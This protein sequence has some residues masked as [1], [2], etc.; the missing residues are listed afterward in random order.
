MA[1]CLHHR[2]SDE[3]RQPEAREA[4]ETFG[5]KNVFGG[6]QLEFQ[7]GAS[8]LHSLVWNERWQ[9]LFQ[10]HRQTMQLGS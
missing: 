4:P 10:F 1:Q 3:E 2:E 7:Q 5:R 9:F 8:V 6:G